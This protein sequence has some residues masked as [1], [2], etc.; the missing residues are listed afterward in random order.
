MD[1][2]AFGSNVPTLSQWTG[3]PRAIVQVQALLFASLA[4]S[5]FSA[6]LAMLGKQWLNRYQ[7]TGTQGSAIE[8]SRNRQQKLGGIVVWYFDSVMESLPLMLQVALLLL[9]CAL[10]RY[11]WA[12]NTSVASV[13][14]SATS[15]GA[16][17]YLFIVVA[18]AVSESCPYQTPAAQTS[19]HIYYYLRNRL[20]P[21]LHSSPTI[22]SATVSSNFSRFYAA[23]WCCHGLF[24]MWSAI[25]RPRYL[26][27]N[28][29]V[30]LSFPI[31]LFGALVHDLH[32][33]GRA[34]IRSLIGLG[35]TVFHRLRGS[36]RTTRHWFTRI[37]S[38]RTLGLD[39]KKIVMDLRCILWILQTSLSKTIQLSAFNH[40]TSM[41]D[42]ARF[43]HSLVFACFN[44]FTRCVTV[45]EGK[46]VILQG[47]GKLAAAS[48]NG[49]L[50]T[51]H[52]LATMDPASKAL[53]DL[54]WRYREFFP[55]EVDFTSLPFRSTMSEIHTLANRFGNPRDIRWHNYKMSVQEH[56]QF[57]RRMFQTALE[58][59]Q[60]TQPRKVP[61]WIL[62][63]TLYFLSLG[64]LSLPSAVADCLTIIAI[65]LDCDVS[66]TVVSDERCVEI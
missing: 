2:T 21:I 18:G 38:R 25:K 49:F 11:L 42:L 39:R 37:T 61:R 41:P 63:T 10:S 15:F 48:A 3:P 30:T 47:F 1:N 17:L 27:D 9:G 31:L 29:A 46:V 62:R 35:K 20:L 12:V 23:S 22:V 19:R 53:A 36:H 45:N 43:H 65:D 8:R 66:N 24:Y 33:L 50:R 64:P 52:H 54:Q 40:L 26:T 7:S 55:S 5:I 57:A 16:V 6:F 32:S 51:L 60:Q 14:I 56:A 13:V 58:R 4:I 44:I 28:I 59:Y 34:I